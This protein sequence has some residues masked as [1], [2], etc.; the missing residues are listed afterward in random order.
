MAGHSNKNIVVATEAL[1]NTP[2]KNSV[3]TIMQFVEINSKKIDFCHKKE[4]VLVMGDTGA[5]K[6]TL[7]S[8]ITKAELN[9]NETVE[10][11]GEYIIVDE[12]QLISG[13]NTTVSKTIIPN[14]MVHK[15][16]GTIYY[17]C[18]GFNDSRGVAN[19]ISVS[20]FTRKL[21]NKSSAV[22]FVFVISYLAV[23][24]GAGDRHNFLDLV[25]HAV[26]F[27]KNI[28]KYADGIA[29]IVTKVENRTIE[30]DG[31]IKLVD[32]SRIIDAIAVF[33]SS[34]KV[35]LSVE[36]NG[37]IT[38][39]KR[40]MNN[41]KIKFID[42]LLKKNNGEFERIGILRLANKTGPVANI[43]VI[44]DERRIIKTIINEH[45]SYVKKED[46]D[47]GYTVS[48]ESKNHIH[49]L[50]EDMQ[51]RL[52]RDVERIGDE[53][54]QF[55]LKQEE[56]IVDIKVLM[57][58]MSNACKKISQI[59]NGQLKQFKQELF[60]VLTVLNINSSEECEYNYSC[61]MTFV[62]F[63]QTVSNA[64]L[65]NSFDIT[66]G[67]NDVKKYL[68][69]SYKW[70]NFLMALHKHL[71]AYNVQKRV[72]EYHL[73]SQQIIKQCDIVRCAHRNINDIH[74]KQLTNDVG[75]D[76]YQ[77][78]HDL[79][80]NSF[81][82]KILK[83][84][85]NQALN[86]TLETEH[87]TDTIIVK[88]YNV[89]ISDIVARN[90]DKF[91]EVFALNNLFIDADIIKIGQ[92]AQVSFIAPTWYIIGDRKI[93]L[94]G[95]DGEPHSQSPLGRS[96]DGLPGK[97]GGAAGNFLAIGKKSYDDQ[98]LQIYLD[99]GKGGPGQDG[100]KG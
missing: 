45:L 69:E 77:T 79:Q 39:E 7:V 43:K 76:V 82:L 40:E 18:P 54:K 74:L 42:I 94:N 56:S 3:A 80:L 15:K 19:D 88:G 83:L 37:N 26:T 13:I 71:S 55:Y 35:N 95:K 24:N 73:H 28:D 78:V 49:N 2:D 1:E 70:Y 89:K 57:E 9:S 85:L 48:N 72:E 97:P 10:D 29:L 58:M 87:T 23:Q 62:D 20:Y 44:Q 65:S 46:S 92:N 99:G 93:N 27:I 38:P 91:I 98:N 32:D 22:K 100:E 61:D 5:G 21:L 16:T 36:N 63:L 30:K 90:T 25:K 11:S 67:L 33:L 8:I 47:F 14:L 68:D 52:T 53:I 86:K 59:N 84:V 60:E 6:T 41:K 34:A 17:D 50:M 64:N 66:N 96:K 81:K 31:K 75:C 51:L 12:K 4:V